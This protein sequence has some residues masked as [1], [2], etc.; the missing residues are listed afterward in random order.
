MSNFNPIYVNCVLF[1]DDFENMVFIH[2]TSGPS[3]LSDKYNFVGGKQK[4]G[5]NSIDSIIR[6]IKKES[7]LDV[8]KD[9]LYNIQSKLFEKDGK[10]YKLENFAAILPKATLEKAHTTELDEVFLKNTKDVIIDLFTNPQNYNSD[11]KDLVVL[12]LHKVPDKF[13]N[14]KLYFLEDFIQSREEKFQYIKNI[15]ASAMKAIAQ[16]DANSLK[17]EKPNPSRFNPYD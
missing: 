15:R 12:A 9:S 16:R 11:F 6:E 13:V 7:G 1:S 3:F 10:D 4:I 8:S 14:D 5:E 2:K 17:K